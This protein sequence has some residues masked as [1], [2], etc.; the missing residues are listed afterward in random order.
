MLCSSVRDSEMGE[1]GREGAPNQRDDL[2]P[3]ST[4]WAVVSTPQSKLPWRETVEGSLS[5]VRRAVRVRVGVAL[6]ET[7]ETS[8][9]YRY[10]RVHC[11]GATPGGAV[12]GYLTVRKA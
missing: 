9:L 2:A 3:R 10:L 6:A 11:R 8:G 5:H 12:P 1:H 7:A 4:C